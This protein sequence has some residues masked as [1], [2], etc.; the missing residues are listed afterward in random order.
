MLSNNIILL[1]IF[2]GIG[3]DNYVCVI[4]QAWHTCKLAL[5]CSSTSSDLQG[6]CLDMILES[7]QE[8]FHISEMTYLS[9]TL[10][11]RAGN[12]QTIALAGQIMFKC[13]LLYTNT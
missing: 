6:F 4:K 12:L 7:S 13:T 11:P 10:L 1:T 5:K 3:G 2:G 8:L 9:T